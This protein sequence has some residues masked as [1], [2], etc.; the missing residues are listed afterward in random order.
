MQRHEIRFEIGV[1]HLS[2][3]VVE[4]LIFEPQLTIV[5]DFR[6]SLVIEE[7]IL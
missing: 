7:F 1:L 2:E 6:V 5:H 3:F 4:T